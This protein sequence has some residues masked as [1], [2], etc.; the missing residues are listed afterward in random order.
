[1]TLIHRRA[2]LFLAALAVAS[3]E[4]MPATSAGP[5][6]SDRALAVWDD[7]NAKLKAA[8]GEATTRQ[9][10][11][12]LAA[13]EACGDWQT[14]AE[15]ASALAVAENEADFWARAAVARLAMGDR[16]AAQ[17]DCVKAIQLDPQN[18]RA[19]AVRALLAMRLHA[20]DFSQAKAHAMAA[21]AADPHCGEAL[22]ALGLIALMQGEPGA[23]LPFFERALADGA[24]SA[25]GFYYGIA[26]AFAAGRRDLARRWAERL[27]ELWPA[28]PYTRMIWVGLVPVS[29]RR[30][31]VRLIYPAFSHDGRRVVFWPGKGLLHAADVDR[32]SEPVA[33]TSIDASYGPTAWT[34]DGVVLICEYSS[35]V[36]RLWRW[37]LR[38]KPRIVVTKRGSKKQRFYFQGLTGGG[39]VFVEYDRRARRRVLKL[40]DPTGQEHEIGD[41]PRAI[42]WPSSTLLG[43][44]LALCT[45]RYRSV[46]LW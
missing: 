21:V 24:V 8:T 12:L 16:R 43:P 38:S 31:A 3:L 15:T 40:L 18:A 27:K 10:T 33:E 19:L 28:H 26:C 23:A 20:F 36:L 44:Y 34:V 29:I 13:A 35:R 37:D 22:G 46:V 1:M 11:E 25:P 7:L 6:W 45:V 2:G 39:A 14:I 4:G 32:P 41:I 30:V 17:T 9:M 5:S 42:G